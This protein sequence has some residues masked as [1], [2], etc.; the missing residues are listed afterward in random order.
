MAAWHVIPITA[1]SVLRGDE[2]QRIVAQLMYWL[3]FFF[4]S[5]RRH[6]RLQ[7]D[8]SSDVCS[9]DLQFD[10]PP[11]LL[12]RA[13]PVPL[14]GGFNEA[15]RSVGFGESLIQRQS[16]HGSLLRLGISLFRRKPAIV[17]EEAVRVGQTNIGQGVRRIFLD[18][19]V[20]IADA[21][22]QTLN[23]SLVPEVTPLQIELVSI[24]VLGEVFSKQLLFG[25]TE[26]Q[27]KCPSYLLRDPILYGEDVGKLFVELFGPQGRAVF[28]TH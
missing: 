9:S 18:R 15:Q 3:S 1:V 22:V 8:W 12:L 26:R 24:G 10:G 27:R 5:R 20:E 4:S 2:G 14:V 23:R 13:R 25:A 7:G 19:L 17:T 6:T 16:L 11:V 28:H 21:F